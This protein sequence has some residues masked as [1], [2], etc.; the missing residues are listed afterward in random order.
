MGLIQTGFGPG[1]KNT[2][3]AG[4]KLL[5]VLLTAPLLLTAA[6]A[7]NLIL[8][9]IVVRGQKEAP[10][11]ESLTIRE[12]RESA[13]RDM[14]EALQRVEG[15]NIVRKGAIAN[16]IVLR[17]FQ[18]D[19]INVLVDGV[20]LH[21]ACPNRMD[22]PAFHYDFAQVEQVSVIKG[23]YDLTN[24]GGMGGAVNAITRK[25]RQGT[26]ADLSATYGSYNS[27]SG[28]AAGSYG[29]EDFDAL[30][31]YAYK[32]SKV[33]KDGKGNLITD[34][35]TSVSPNRYRP[36]TKDSK[37]YEIN[38]YW[39][40]AGFRPTGNI[41]T[42]L[43]YSFQDAQHVL[44]P[45]L[46][47]DGIF[48]KTS[49]VNWTYNF[50]KVSPS[51]SNLKFQV[52][53]DKVDHLMDD[54]L[55]VSSL[56]KSR[57]YSMRSDATTETSGVKAQADLALG[58]G[59]LRG[60]ADVYSRNWNVINRRAMYLNYTALNMIPDATILNT[61]VFAQYE[62][63]VSDRV[64]LAG[65][66]RGDFAQAKTET[67]NPLVAANTKKNFSEASG[68][69]QLTVKPSAGLE[70]FAGLA[71]GTRLPDQKE[72]FLSI[73]GAPKNTFGKPNLKATANNEA[74]LGAKYS[75]DKFYVNA[76]VFYS[77]LKNY[78]NARG[79]L[80]GV[81]SN[82]TYENVDAEIWGGEIGSQVSLPADLFV[83]AGL[84]YTRG[85]NTTGG[86]PLSE[87]PPLKG[88]AA[89]RYDNN[90]WF[91]E[92]AENMATRQ[93]RVD[94]SLQ[95]V[96]T[97]GWATT[98]LKAGYTY[99]NLSVYAGVYNVFD[100]FYYTYLSY[101]RDPFASGM[102]VP[103]SGRNFYITATYRL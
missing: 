68:N 75:T 85:N 101:L 15:I 72:L 93:T 22:S 12:V 36:D 66:A 97:A 45:Y 27:V 1:R 32:Y 16:D 9:E 35:Y 63:P 29:S 7:A 76:S 73:P 55:R 90:T 14:G 38:T 77:S 96:E 56:A 94:S 50:A 78:I 65:G 67:A 41:S 57:S 95:E 49:I 40:R 83:K 74:D 60:G 3:K 44:Y 100:K 53:W 91:A 54:T 80:S 2:R 10:N 52:Y 59:T 64:T 24:P 39:G 25:P 4:R 89:L 71:R 58:G 43:S 70:L 102:K 5:L 21:G 42:D 19:N 13:A 20:R 11:Q 23:P 33:P 79:F 37:A 48:D 30:A 47:M 92:A 17:G 84:S 18:R 69:V 6:G 8:D 88:T 61:G 31:G 98:D 99:K 62:R 103:E 28:S 87:M 51:V 82:I 81:I 34:I 86:R 26:G 46:L